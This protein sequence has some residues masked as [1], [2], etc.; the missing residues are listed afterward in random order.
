MKGIF[1]LIGVI[2]LVAII[3]LSMT[4]CDDSSGG[5]GGGGNSEYEILTP[6]GNILTIND[7]QVYYRLYRDYEKYYEEYTKPGTVE[8]T[9]T[10]YYDYDGYLAGTNPSMNSSGAINA[11]IDGSPSV[12]I[13]NGKLSISL[14]TPKSNFMSLISSYLHISGNYGYSINPSNAKFF[15]F[16][17]CFF[18]VDEYGNALT[19]IINYGIMYFYFNEDVTISYGS[20]VIS[21]K[22]GWYCDFTNEPNRWD[23]EEPIDNISGKITLTDITNLTN[24]VGSAPVVRL[25]CRNNSGLLGSTYLTFS[26]S[27]TQTIKWSIPIYEDNSIPCTG[28]FFMDINPKDDYRSRFTISI[29]STKNIDSTNKS[30]IDLGTV[31]LK[32]LTLKG[33][34][35]YKEQSVSYCRIIASTSDFTS[36]GYIELNSPTVGASWQIIIPAS[37]SSSSEQVKIRVNGEDV[38]PTSGAVMVNKDDTEKTGIVLNLGN[39]TE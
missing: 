12:K 1:K 17:P 24:T 31:S 22:K 29:P 32:T 3:G 14:G 21:L 23:I 8:L 10:Y 28:N 39:I 34:I 11:I 30:N 5:G 6:I 4:T 27:D 13:M 7:V 2:A 18:N 19:E 37:T 33:T 38:T 36:G 35:T 9:N 15:M 26:G 16:R 25:Y 20:D